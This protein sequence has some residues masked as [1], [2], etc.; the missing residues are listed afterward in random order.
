MGARGNR[1]KKWGQKY[2]YKERLRVG[3]EREAESREGF[4]VKGAPLKTGQRR[5]IV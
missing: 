4:V 1:V 3:V 5:V 2:V